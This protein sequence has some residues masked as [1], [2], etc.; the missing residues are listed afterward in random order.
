MWFFY[1]TQNG[2]RIKSWGRPSNGFVLGVDF[3]QVVMNNVQNPIV[4]DQNYCPGN[5]GCPNQN[6]G[7]KIS[8]V[9]YKDIKGS[10][11]SPVAIKF[12][13]SA[14]SPC[15]SIGLHDI[16]LTYQ[17]KPADS[18]CRKIRGMAWGVVTPP[19]CL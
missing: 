16:K 1:G 2:L 17:N 5:E 19:S 4:R 10:S 7:V 15:R 6:S 13:C 18:F 14:M 12:D 8:R 3:R 9:T 11:A